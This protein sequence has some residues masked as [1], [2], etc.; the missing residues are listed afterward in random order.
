M[1]VTFA[2]VFAMEWRFV[3]LELRN[4]RMV[5]FMSVKPPKA[6]VAGRQWHF[7]FVPSAEV[8]MPV[9]EPSTASKAKIVFLDRRRSGPDEIELMD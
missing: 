9:E 7:C 2:P 8:A 5:R 4:R 6:E 3:R 1:L